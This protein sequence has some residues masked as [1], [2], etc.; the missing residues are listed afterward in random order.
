[1]FIVEKNKVKISCLMV[2]AAE[3][4]EYFVRSFQC[5]KDQ[6]YLNKELIVVNEG[7][8]EYQE[9]IRSYL[10]NRKDVRFVFLDG[11]YSLGTLRNISISLCSGDVFVQWDD[12]DFNMPS[13]LAIQFSHL[14]K[15]QSAKYCFFTDQ[16]HYYFN[17]KKLYWNDWSLFHSGNRKEYSLIPGTIMA[18]RKEF[19]SRYPT[20]G[21][22][23]SAG[24]DSIL[25]YDLLEDEDSVLLLNGHGNLHVY[26]YHGK[27]VWDIEHHEKICRERSLPIAQLIEKRE[28]IYETLNY[29]N[30]SDSIDIM[31]R[32]GMAFNFRN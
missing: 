19:H 16:L 2:T 20:S 27:N 4:F 7:P 6:T 1:M 3:R 9:K 32:D 12:D 17:N 11:K 15:N 28:K 18:W 25:A 13:R 23:C 10:E 24:E 14:Y 21:K 30:L 29:L 5:Y 26:S 8:K 22:Y 31:G